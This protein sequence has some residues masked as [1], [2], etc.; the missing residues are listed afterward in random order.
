MD[1]QISTEKL[2]FS[3][4]TLRELAACRKNSEAAVYTC[5]QKLIDDAE[6]FRKFHRKR[7]EKALQRS[8][9][10][11]A[12][13]NAYLQKHLATG[14]KLKT[15]RTAARRDFIAAH[16]RPKNADDLIRANE[17]PGLSRPAIR[18]YHKAYLESL[19]AGRRKP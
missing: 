18:Q 9:Q 15:A 10:W 14:L 8:I 16:P 5:L 6:K 3:P 17:F 7:H 19:L 11:G 4:E 12:E 13:Y 1:L 2:K